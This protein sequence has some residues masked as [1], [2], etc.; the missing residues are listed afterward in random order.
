MFVFLSFRLSFFSLCFSFVLFFSLLSLAFL[1]LAFDQVLT[2][3]LLRFVYD[4]ASG[5]KKK[6][7]S[8]IRFPEVLDMRPFLWP[9]PTPLSQQEE[10]RG[11]ADDELIY[12]LQAVLVHRGASA[13]QGHYIAHAFDE[14]WVAL[15]DLG[16]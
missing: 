9:L 15:F 16:V 14:M 10:E 2:F 13:Y 5:S 7:K 4:L 1:W 6:V 11:E 12:E 8:T 3:Q